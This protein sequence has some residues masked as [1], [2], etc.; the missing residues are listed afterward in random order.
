[1]FLQVIYIYAIDFSSS[2]I[3]TQ[4]TCCSI[5]LNQV[6][7][8]T[9][10][11]YIWQLLMDAWV[12]IPVTQY[13]RLSAKIL[14]LELLTYCTVMAV[15]VGLQTTPLNISHSLLPTTPSVVQSLCHKQTVL[16]LTVLSIHPF[17]RLS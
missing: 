12:I 9:I 16:S 10:K 6:P 2:L 7:L 5:L 14:S 4:V 8:C 17:R 13:N 1:M 11:K 3:C 15:L